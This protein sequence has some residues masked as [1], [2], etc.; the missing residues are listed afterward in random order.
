ME[1][2]GFETNQLL[3]HCLL[4][5]IDTSWSFDFRVKRLSLFYSKAQGR[6][7]EEKRIAG[8]DILSRQKKLRA[9]SEGA[10]R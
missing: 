6:D 3:T 5:R 4:A 2:Y 9:E 1:V 7:E 8:T 10:N